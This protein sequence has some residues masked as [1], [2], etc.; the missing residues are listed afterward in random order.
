MG[1]FPNMCF[2]GTTCPSVIIVGM[3]AMAVMGYGVYRWMKSK[4][5]R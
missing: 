5:G 1:G 4:K 2:H 3:M